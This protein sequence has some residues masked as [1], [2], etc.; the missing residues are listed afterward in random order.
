MSDDEARGMQRAVALAYDQAHG[1]RG[2]RVLARGY[3]PLA[4]L[5]IAEARQ[6]GIKVHDSPA[7]VALLMQLDIDQRI[8]PLLYQAIGELVAW[9]GELEEVTDEA[10]ESGH[11]QERST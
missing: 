1:E 3:G 7:L 6:H 5:I 9:I 8:P 11:D 2:A 10:L 4:E